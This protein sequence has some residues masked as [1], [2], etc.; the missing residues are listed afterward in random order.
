[1]FAQLIPGEGKVGA[2]VWLLMFSF[3]Q[4]TVWSSL[5][6]SLMEK[7]IMDRN[8][9]GQG[10][11]CV[12]QCLLL[13][14]SWVQSCDCWIFC[15]LVDVH[16]FN[17][18]IIAAPEVRQKYNEKWELIVVSVE[19]D[20]SV[21]ETPE[22]V[23]RVWLPSPRTRRSSWSRWRSRAWGPACW[24]S[25]ACWRARSGAAL[26]VAC[27]HCR[28]S[29]RWRPWESVSAGAAGPFLP[30]V[31]C[32][33]D[34]RA[35]LILTQIIAL[36]SYVLNTSFKHSQS[37][38]GRNP[39]A[40]EL[41]KTGMES[42]VKTGVQSMRWDCWCDFEILW[43]IT[44]RRL[45]FAFHKKHLLVTPEDLRSK[46]VDLH[47]TGKGYRVASKSLDIHQTVYKWRVLYWG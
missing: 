15:L 6:L 25:T 16:T 22:V 19:P 40:D 30:A 41:S 44:L 2:V 43:L 12:T 24:R 27:R 7:G 13:T 31:C 45:Q 47:K 8:Y 3:I 4:W 23:P 1:M 32:Y 5:T 46:C 42:G 21:P 11:V 10:G 36:L 29:A 9:P 14:E 35:I 33:L 37:G 26:L 18:L 20:C 34:Q 17:A 38:L 28:R 39:W